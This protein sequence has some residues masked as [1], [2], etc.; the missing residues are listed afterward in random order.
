MA[1]TSLSSPSSAVQ[2]GL[3]Q[4]RLQQARRTAEQAEQVARSLQTQAQEAQQ[5]ASQAQEEARSIAAQ[6]TQAQGVA[7]QARQG[8][9][10]IESVSQMR[11]QLGKIVR[12]VADK[13][14]VA[15]GAVPGP[16]ATAAVI[17][18]AVT[19]VP[20]VNV[21]GQTTGTVINTTA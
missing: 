9:K 15:E 2:Y 11:T 10:I 13:V 16:V 5:Q 4:L 19:P 3:A 1:T 6:A 18:A 14:K 21:E 7:G 17:K 12:P 8:V 20:V